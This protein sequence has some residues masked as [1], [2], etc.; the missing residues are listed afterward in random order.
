MCGRSA[1]RAGASPESAHPFTPS[2][3]S[4]A[5]ML[6]LRLVASSLLLIVTIGCGSD[7]T[8]P[9]NPSPVPA[10]APAPAPTPGNASASVAIVVGASTL[11]NRAYTPD[12]VNVG[13]G[14]TETWTNGDSVAHTST[15]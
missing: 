8:A 10:P 14:T 12:D 4:E 11:G 15:S 2:S 6:S 5:Q 1:R 13:V 7:Y 9:A 3:A